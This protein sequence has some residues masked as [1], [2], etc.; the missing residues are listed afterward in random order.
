MEC[1][2]TGLRRVLDEATAGVAILCRV[3]GGDDLH[4]LDAIH[5][6]RALLALLMSAGVA[7]RSAVEEVLARHGLAAVDPRV[8]LAAAE[9]RVAVRLHRE[10][11]GLHG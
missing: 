3:A 10:V 1:V 11:A 4:F 6:R 2:S 5:R 9:H 7:K 8:E